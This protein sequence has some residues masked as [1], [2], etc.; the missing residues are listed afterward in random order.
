MRKIM[1]FVVLSMTTLWISSCTNKPQQAAIATDSVDTD[2]LAVTDSTIYGRCGDGTAMH[3]LELVTDKGDT[4]TLGINDEDPVSNVKGGLSVGDRMAVIVS[5]DASSDIDQA[6]L[7]VNLTT[8]LGK[9]VSL[10]KNFE[11]K[12]GGAV[13]SNAKEPKPYTEWKIFNGKLVLSADTFSIYELGADSL[14]LENEK[15]IYAYKRLK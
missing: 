9:W 4:L 13:V 11:L 5:K 3:T 10:D 7:V 1:Y 8:L 12:E 14:Y 6:K 15:G 2:T